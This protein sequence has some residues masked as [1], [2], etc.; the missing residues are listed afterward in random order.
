MRR[1]SRNAARICSDPARTSQATET[2]S[3]IV[4]LK[5]SHPF[6]P[7]LELVI[8]CGIRSVHQHETGARRH[9]SFGES[10]VWSRQVQGL[11][12]N[13]NA[14][15]AIAECKLFVKEVV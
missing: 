11:A 14:E 6:G 1:L 2:C 5:A 12:L 3:F 10:H 4:I 15:L 8:H 7:S 9:A 13:D